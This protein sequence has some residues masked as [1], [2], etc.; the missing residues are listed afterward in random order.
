[1]LK[2]M[3][4]YGAAHAEN[5]DFFVSAEIKTLNSKFLDL[6]LRISHTFSD[7]EIEIKNWL[8]EKIERGKVALSIKF[9]PK[10]QAG[11]TV[12]V[13]VPVVSR[14]YNEL[15]HTANLLGADT[16]DIF[17]IAMQLPD[18]FIQE[19]NDET[20]EAQWRF[21]S[22]VILKAI[23]DCND[24]RL[25]EGKVLAEKILSYSRL[26]EVLLD[27]VVERD[28]ERMSNIREKIRKH[29]A[30]FVA[31]EHF[32]ANR[33]EQEIVY[34][35]EKYDITEEKVRLKN[36]LNYF[37]EVLRQEGSNGK[38]LGFIVQEIGREI[39]TIGSK[40]NDSIIQ[41]LVV[42]MKDELEKIKEQLQNIL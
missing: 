28:P 42:E 2:S 4:G 39:N 29:I 18:A 22:E 8:S 35:S 31:D 36:H 17:R 20:R 33:F 34:Y 7:K 11:S 16:K 10:A 24:F 27:K 13:N 32:D 12:S 30:D 1:M 21:A 23:Q 37:E 3:T 14:L 38:K 41:R 26:I 5:E 9:V 40:A 6:S 25:R 19:S 15:L